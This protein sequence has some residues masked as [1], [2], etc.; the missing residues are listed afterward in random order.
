MPDM[1]PEKCTYRSKG[2]QTEPNAGTGVSMCES[3]DYT[4][5]NYTDCDTFIIKERL[6]ALKRMGPGALSGIRVI[7]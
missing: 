2:I 1:S 6:D 3:C 7:T 5:K 4:G